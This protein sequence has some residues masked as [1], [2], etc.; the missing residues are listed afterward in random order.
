M[1]E[2]EASRR[3]LRRAK[4]RAFFDGLGRALD[5]GGASRIQAPAPASSRAPRQADTDRHAL[6]G[7]WA[8]IAA[9][10]ARIPVPVRQR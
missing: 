8:R 6:E 10:F 2:N 7:D 4:L 9:D 1:A 3:R 5:L